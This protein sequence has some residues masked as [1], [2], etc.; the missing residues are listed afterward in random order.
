MKNK[1]FKIFF[2]IFCC[3]VLS[4]C[5]FYF[6]YRERI[7]AMLANPET[8]FSAALYNVKRIAGWSD[9]TWRMFGI[10]LSLTLCCLLVE[11]LFTGWD[12]SSLKRLTVRRDNSS[13]S[14]LWLW[15]LGVFQLYNL[16]VLLFSFGIFYVA[17]SMMVKL[18]DFHLVTHIANPFL[19]F[20]IVLIASDL[21]HYIRHALSHK[22]GWFWELHKYHHSAEHLN[23][24]TVQRGH[25]LETAVIT[26]F[27]AALFVL[28]G[29]PVETYLSIVLIREAHQM[30][31]H[32]EVNWKWGWLGKYILVSPAAHQIHHSNSPE[33]YDN[34]YGNMFI[35]WDRVFNSW[36]DPNRNKNPITFGVQDNPYNK[37]GFFNDM[38][39][40]CRL[41]INRV[42]N[43][44]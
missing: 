7:S 42:K 10:S 25:F 20:A 6:Y 27:D 30:F 41:F 35:F 37:A 38:I 29:S 43:Y 23:M 34:N 3:V 31:I 18:F 28:T 26:L 13:S 16:L 33:H 17:I 5:L 9:F 2:F 12:K 32:S 44:F 22:I 1:N 8:F 4:S 21:K 36:Y 39:L 40:V 19:Q 11:L 14:D 15:L 24:I